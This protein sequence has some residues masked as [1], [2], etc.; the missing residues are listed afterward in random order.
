MDYDDG[1]SCGECPAGYTGSTVRG[2]DLQD[3][4]SLQQVHIILLLLLYFQVI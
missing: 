3:A 4:V 2:Y 1:F